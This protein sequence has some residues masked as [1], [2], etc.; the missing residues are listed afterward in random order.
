M[1]NGQEKSA[2]K[3]TRIT[4]KFKKQD[5][6]LATVNRKGSTKKSVTHDELKRVTKFKKSTNL[7]KLA[8][9]AKCQSQMKPLLIPSGD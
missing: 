5:G 1:S 7:K 2:K 9:V 6:L 8:N 4:F 3:C